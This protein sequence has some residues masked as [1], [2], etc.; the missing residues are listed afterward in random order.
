MQ[1]SKQ[2]QMEYVLEIWCSSHQCSFRDSYN[3]NQGIFKV[4]CWLVVADTLYV[5]C[6]SSI[7]MCTA[8]Y[9]SVLGLGLVIWVLL[10]REMTKCTVLKTLIHSDQFWNDLIRPQSCPSHDKPKGLYQSVTFRNKNI[11]NKQCW[12]LLKDAEIVFSVYKQPGACQHVFMKHIC[13]NLYGT[14]ISQPD[15]KVL[16][17]SPSECMLGMLVATSIIPE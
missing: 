4:F 7:C 11:S 12:H 9:M 13:P 17:S 15:S 16:S 5:F 2:Q 3:L 14:V 8:L 1:L 6:L 10:I